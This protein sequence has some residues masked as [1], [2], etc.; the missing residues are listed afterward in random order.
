MKSISSP[1][2]G[3]PILDGRLVSEIHP[4]LDRSR[5]YL[6]IGPNIYDDHLWKELG[7]P[8]PRPRIDPA[9]LKSQFWQY[10]R[11][12]RNSLEP[13]RFSRTIAE[14]NAPNV[15]LLM[16]ANV[17]HINTTEDGARVESL[18]V[19]TLNG[20]RAEAKAKTI[21]LACGGLENARL[22]LASNKHAQRCRKFA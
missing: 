22:L 20:R 6:G 4:F 9:F 13:V 10:S 1:G 14:K 8:L 18:D 11:D 21:V 16:H 5:K 3:F 19:R 2:L 7:I 12:D 17:T 15:K